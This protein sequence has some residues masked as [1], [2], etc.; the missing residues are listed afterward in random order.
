LPTRL[1][2]GKQAPGIFGRNGSLKLEKD[3]S[4]LIAIEKMF[5]KLSEKQ[6]KLL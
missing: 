6:S 3:A 5:G 1:Y 4:I 2:S